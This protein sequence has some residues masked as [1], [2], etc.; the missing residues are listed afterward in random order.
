MNLKTPFYIDEMYEYYQMYEYERDGWDY[1][2][3]VTKIGTISYTNEILGSFFSKFNIIPSWINC[4]F[5]WGMFD[6][7]TEHWTGAIGQV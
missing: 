3:I 5:T 4:N 1:G 7:E 2:F 6:Y